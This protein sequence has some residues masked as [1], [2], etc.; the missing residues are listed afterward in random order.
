MQRDIGE[1]WRE[2][3]G[4]PLR[5]DLLRQAEAE[6]VAAMA[7]AGDAEPVAQLLRRL[8][9]G[10]VLGHLRS[11]QTRRVDGRLL[12]LMVMTGQ[13]TAEQALAHAAGGHGEHEVLVHVWR[14]LPLA[15]LREALQRLAWGEEIFLDHRELGPAL[16]TAAGDD[17]QDQ[18]LAQAR[19]APEPARSRLLVELLPALTAARREEALTDLHAGLLELGGRL[20][21][22]GLL[23]GLLAACSAE[24]RAALA[25]RF[26]VPVGDA[27]L[28]LRAWVD[29]DLERAFQAAEETEGSDL[30]PLCVH[31]RVLGPHVTL[32]DSRR[33][34]ALVRRG[35]TRAPRFLYFLSAGVPASLW[36]E[37]V[38]GMPPGQALQARIQLACNDPDRD[39]AP[40]LAEYV[41]AGLGKSGWSSLIELAH[42][43]PEPGRS[44]AAGVVLAA[45]EGHWLAEFA[46]RLLLP[47]TDH[48]GRVAALLR[49]EPFIDDPRGPGYAHGAFVD[50]LRA[51]ARRLPESER[52]AVLL[53]GAV[54]LD[55]LPPATRVRAAEALGQEPDEDSRAVL[56]ARGEASQQDADRLLYEAFELRD[57]D[58][59]WVALKSLARQDDE[60]LRDLYR[61]VQGTEFALSEE[62]LSFPVWALDR[63]LW[64]E[65]IQAEELRNG[66]VP[67]ELLLQ[68]AKVLDEPER[69]VVVDRGLDAIEMAHPPLP[70]ET[71]SGHAGVL[72]PGQVRRV[73][74]WVLRQDD[75]HEERL[76]LVSELAGRLLE[77]GHCG[78]AVAMIRGIH[79]GEA[80]ARELGRMAGLSARRGESAIGPVDTAL[81]S[82]RHRLLYVQAFARELGGSEVIVRP[83]VAGELLARVSMLGDED[84]RAAALAAVIG[85]L[86]AGASLTPWTAAIHRGTRGATRR[87]LLLVLFESADLEGPLAVAR[88]REVAADL[89]AESSPPAEDL[90]AACLASRCLPAEER[91]PLWTR[92]LGRS[93][94]ESRDVLPPLKGR[95]GAVFL[96]TLQELGGASALVQACDVLVDVAATLA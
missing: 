11:V 85:S 2:Y 46:A 5:L 12:A 84:S 53:R 37:A 27:G 49:E 80:G 81:T 3:R 88:V 66:Q 29:A 9:D 8:R 15:A 75:P 28:D 72:E 56:A 76:E 17:W 41:A 58:A 59:R 50:V 82:D 47:A 60:K 77:L 79:D 73:V 24:E 90:E 39:L 55:S 48:A 71:L 87:R 43:A 61:R 38:E 63:E 83:D 64:S 45:C 36:P 10:L 89:L 96:D 7:T 42:A 94:D 23:R 31:L 93:L 4:D 52:R 18:A 20:E 26:A 16:R 91:V 68:Y 25:R 34:L 70:L 44:A 1:L 30:E 86:P 51:W 78:E 57:R 21:Q 62:I 35:L 69:S 92:W 95:L 13:T 54:C 40:L 65:R 6:V 33:W 74:A 19:R 22:L 32:A 14:Q 67:G